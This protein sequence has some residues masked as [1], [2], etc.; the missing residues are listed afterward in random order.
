MDKERLPDTIARMISPWAWSARQ[1]RRGFLRLAGG[2]AAAATLFPVEAGAATR[3]HPAFRDYPFQLGVASGDPTPDGFVI[4]TRLAPDPLNGGGMTTESIEVRWEVA[5]D[6]RFE[7]VVLRGSTIASAYWAHAVH[8]EVGGLKPER[9]YWYRFDS[10]GERS[11]VGRT[12]T[13]PPLGSAG[14]AFRFAFASCQHFETGLYT[15]YRHMLADNVD[16]VVHLGDYIY[17][18]PATKDR[19]RAHRGPEIR[20]LEQYRNRYALYRSDDALQAMHAAAPWVVTWDD[21]EVDNNYADDIS[22][23]KNV[24]PVDLLKRRAIAYKAYYEHMPLRRAQ[25]PAGPAL[26]LYREMAW[27]RLARFLVLDTRQYRT[28][29]PCDDGNKPQCADA[30]RPDATLLGR[31]QRDW[32]FRRTADRSA[33]WNVLAQQV[34]MARVD[35]KS[36]PEEAFSMDQWPGY[37]A[38]RRR[39]LDHFHQ[40]R[41]QN[42]VVLTG[43]IHTNWANDLDRAYDGSNPGPV[44]V[45]FVGTSISS[46]GDGVDQPAYL[47]ALLSEN[48]AVKFHNTERGYVLCDVTRERW[49]TEYRTVP[50]VTRPGAPVQTRARFAVE[51]G[52]TRLQKG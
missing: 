40:A 28:D 17:E 37:E 33:L 32:L 27:G 19:I 23:E 9:W 49:Q 45:E 16:L 50:Y 3:R 14:S 1:D 18:G 10:G 30:L 8:V 21:H 35:R 39:V 6:E 2:A 13:T 43:D 29:Q 42:P 22:E 15:A 52:H 12:R 20:T 31:R 46:G 44:G 51:P 34:M 26:Q 47:P 11:P 4:W 7:R 24:R 25:Q 48:P 41:I 36:G 5:E 38:D